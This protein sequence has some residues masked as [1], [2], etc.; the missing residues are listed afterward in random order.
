MCVQIANA[1]RLAM[2][3]EAQ[4]LTPPPPVDYNAWAQ[5][6]IVFTERESPFPGPYSP[7]QFPH[8][9][10]IFNALSPDD[11][12]R[13]IT[14][15]GSA[16]VGKTV[17][18]NIFT[19]GSMSMDPCDLLIVHPTEDNARR[20]SKMK[21]VPM[22]KGTTALADIF[23][24]KPRDGLDSVLYKERK[25]GSA[26]IL[27]SGANSPSSLSQ[28]TMRRQ[29]Q[30]DLSKWETNAAGDPEIQADNRSRAHEFAKVLKLG[31]PLVLP[32]CRITR[33]YEAGS[34]EQPY[35]PCPHCQFEQV[36]EWETMLACTDAEH[37]ETAHFTCLKC[38][39]KIE[40]HHRPEMLKRLAWRAHNEPAKREHRSFWIWS[41]YSVLQSFER[42][43]RE[44]LKAKGDADAEK[45][46]LNDTCGKAYR[47]ASEAPPWEKLRDRAASSHYRIGLVPAGG[48]LLFMGI[49]CQVD[50]VE[51]HVI[52][53]GKDFH[54][55]VVDYRVLSGH[56][57]E[58][59]CQSALDAMLKQTYPN[60]FG[61]RLPIELS[62]IDGNAWTEDVW[63]WARRHPK[64]KLI[65]VRGRGEDSAPRFARVK[66]ERHDRTGKLLK[67]ASRFYNFGSSILKM[68]LYRDLAKED[69]LQRGAVQFPTGLEDE[70]FRQLTAER[71]EPEKRH[72]FTV[73]RWKKDD[74]QA[75][76]ALDTW[77]QAE[78]AATKFGVR[79]MPDE[80][81]ARYEREREVPVQK[82]QVDL[83]DL[84]M[85]PPSV[86]T[87][88]PALATAPVRRRRMRGGVAS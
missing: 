52:A 38:G 86:P 6:N 13:T 29:V 40:E 53:F 25:D 26:A 87:V 5:R 41:A 11:P 83:E 24:Q 32:G 43:Y 2:E 84:M 39:E 37:P 18:G 56:I 55:S 60:E 16:Q 22:L 45:T 27:I 73:Y 81:W 47:A 21:L 28:V 35:V 3:A 71:R 66:K 67:Y 63:G 77:C 42:I 82:G 36:L 10:E 62:A 68:S 70:Y 75:N 54:R 34:Q 48:L 61:H 14:L 74:T 19:G 88:P 4:A 30:D 69:P 49:D 57:T 78:A 20:W 65:M 7:S 50:R 85:A 64:S 44:W 80:L 23:P 15:M 12:C 46:F 72:G 33:S 58:E 17:V 79:G 1:A 76:E 31:T 59:R 51:C 9:T 8:L